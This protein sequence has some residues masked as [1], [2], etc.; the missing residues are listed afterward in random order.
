MFRRLCAFAVFHIIIVNDKVNESFQKIIKDRFNYL[1]VKT[2]L[3]KARQKYKYTIL[4]REERRSSR[5]E[6]LEAQE[7]LTMSQVT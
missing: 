4:E 1:G 7:R 5:G 2:I 6:T 3:G